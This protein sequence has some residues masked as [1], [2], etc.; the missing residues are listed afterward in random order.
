LIAENPGGTFHR[1]VTSEGVVF[2]YY[3]AG[4]K[5]LW[6]LGVARGELTQNGLAK[7]RAIS[8]ISFAFII[9]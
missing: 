1:A 9:Y 2:L 3:R 6:F 7:P 4:G 8:M 5:G